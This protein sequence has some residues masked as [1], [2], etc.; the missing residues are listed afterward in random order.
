MPVTPRN[1]VRHELIGLEVKVVEA[2]VKSYVGIRGIV[3]YETKNTLWIKTEKG[4]KK[5]LKPGARFLFILPSG[6]KVLVEGEIVAKRP[7]DRL[8]IRIKRWW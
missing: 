2:K 6:C 5:I 8:K 4:V 1:I 3:V 7:E